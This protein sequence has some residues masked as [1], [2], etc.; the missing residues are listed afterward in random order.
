MVV[1]VV[2]VVVV[3][4]E[5]ERA[6]WRWTAVV[7]FREEKW[8]GD[9]SQVTTRKRRAHFLSVSLFRFP[10]SF[11]VLVFFQGGRFDFWFVFLIH[12]VAISWFNLNTRR[13]HECLTRFLTCCVGPRAKEFLGVG[14][15][16]RDGVSPLDIHSIY[17]SCSKM[18]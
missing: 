1:E 10:N 15:V 11:V 9:A 7:R 4:R 13:V 12:W 18:Y 8:W 14:M 6:W 17:S 3:V 2:V 16:P 5:G